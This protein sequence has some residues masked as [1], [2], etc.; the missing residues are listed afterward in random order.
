MSAAFEPD[1]SRKH[2]PSAEELEA[3]VRAQM[4]ELREEPA[5]LLERLESYVGYELGRR[6]AMGQLDPGDVQR[7]E[8]VDTAFALAL[9][10]LREG[11]PIRDLHTY[12]RSRAQEM[13]RREVRRVANER[14]RVVSLDQVISNNEDSEDGEEIRLADVIPDTESRELD[15][16]AIDAETMSYMINALSDLPELWRSIFLER[17]IQ[18]RSARQIAEHEDM[19]IDEVRRIVVRSRDFLRDKMENE[20]GILDADDF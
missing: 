7:D 11:T 15:A 9:N 5:E 6:T 18:G 16:A 3:L 2:R 13:I 20:F 12:L 8:V 4:D 14:R 1:G 17:T 19:H 10:R